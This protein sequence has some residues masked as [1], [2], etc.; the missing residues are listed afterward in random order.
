MILKEL[1]KL[2]TWRKKTSSLLKPMNLRLGFSRE[3]LALPFFVGL[4]LDAAA[5]FEFAWSERSGRCD[6]S[7]APETYD[8]AIRFQSRSLS[9]P[10]FLWRFDSMQQH[11][12]SLH[13]AKEAEDAMDQAL[14][15]PMILHLGFSWEV[16]A[17]IFW[18]IW[19]DAA[20][21]YEFGWSKGAGS[22][23]GSKAFANELI[24]SIRA[25]MAPPVLV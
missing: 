14:L 12:S 15:K 4:W 20:V 17:L 18:G 3:V 22:C 6:G 7:S 24:H 19:L 1:C 2:T 9:P 5:R 11:D 13:G 8:F 10:L 16:L 21:R 23:D 25:E